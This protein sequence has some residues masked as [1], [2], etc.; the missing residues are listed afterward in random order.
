MKRRKT[1]MPVQVMSNTPKGS[2]NIAAKIVTIEIHMAIQNPFA[3]FSRSQNP[4]A[5]RNAVKN[6]KNGM[7]QNGSVARRLA[8]SGLA[9]GNIRYQFG[10]TPSAINGIQRLSTNSMVA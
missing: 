5:M 1:T 9:M 7:N 4:E 8:I 2:K 10:K 6:Q 3:L